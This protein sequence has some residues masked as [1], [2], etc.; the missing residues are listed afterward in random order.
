[1]K[2]IALSLLAVAGLAGAAL[3]QQPAA[4]TA[5]ATPTPPAASTAPQ[6]R[7]AVANLQALGGSGVAGT[8]S[9]TRRGNYIAVSANIRGLRPGGHGFHIHERGDCS[10][11]DGTSAGGH[12]NPGNQQHGNPNQPQHHAGDLP[13]LNASRNGNARLSTRLTGVR[14][15]Q[16]DTGIIGRAVIIHADPDD[17]TTQ[18]TGNSGGRIACAVITAR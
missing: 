3:A 13:M 10:A 11:P 2:P 15:D 12:F 5:P 4:P 14:L 6:A 8:V 18:P 1:M 7:S 16:S 17:Y 9:F